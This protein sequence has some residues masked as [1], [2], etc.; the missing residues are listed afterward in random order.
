[1]EIS[2]SEMLQAAATLASG[3]LSAYDTGNNAEGNAERVLEQ[4]YKVVR[5]VVERREKEVGEHATR[6]L[7]E[8]VES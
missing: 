3:I 5:K 2:E 4:S 6:Q 8:W 1:M 7:N